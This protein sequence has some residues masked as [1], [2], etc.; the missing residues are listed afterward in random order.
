MSAVFLLPFDHSEV[1][2]LG[3]G[4]GRLEPE[5]VESVLFLVVVLGSEFVVFLFLEEAEMGT[6]LGLGSLAVLS[7]GFAVFI[8]GHGVG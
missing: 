3:V 6:G 4:E 5:F 7:V 1:E 2:L 8:R